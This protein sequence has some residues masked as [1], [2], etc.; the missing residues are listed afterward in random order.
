MAIKHIYV[1]RGYLPEVLGEVESLKSFENDHIIKC[2]DS[3]YD[4]EELYLNIVMELCQSSL[5]EQIKQKK[6]FYER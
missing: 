1:Q 6:P 3:F 4:S 5:R 2:K